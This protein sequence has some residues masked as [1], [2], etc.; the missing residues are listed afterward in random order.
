MN[1]ENLENSSELVKCDI[2]GILCKKKNRGNHARKHEH[3]CG[4]SCFGLN[5]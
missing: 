4:I 2:C 5:G 1:S 3:K